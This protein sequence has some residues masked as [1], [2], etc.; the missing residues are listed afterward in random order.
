[1]RYGILSDIHANLE[2]LH[3]VLEDLRIQGCRHIACLG[4]IV[5]YGANPKECLDLIRGMAIPAV[6]GN[7]DEYAAAE[8]P[9]A[10]L[11][12]IDVERIAWTRAQLTAADREWLRGLSP[13]LSV[14]DLTLVH[15][16]LHNPRSW[17]YVFENSSA[18]ASLECQ[19]TQVCFFG[20]TH[21]PNAFVRDGTG[22]K[23]GTYTTLPIEAGKQYFVNVGS[24]GQPRD[25]S[26]QAAY[27]VYDSGAQTIELRRVDSPMKKAR[28]RI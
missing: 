8:T 14:A 16:T 22:V 18:A 21:I 5:G 25:G 9:P 28:T 12:D 17:E 1:M 26:S 7:H 13:V 10:G 6:L 20:H 24:V 27:A 19:Y 4:D 15:A 11:R 2:A 3:A 23:G